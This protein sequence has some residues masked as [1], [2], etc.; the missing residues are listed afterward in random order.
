MCYNCPPPYFDPN[1]N[2]AGDGYPLNGQGCPYLPH[3]DPH[4]MFH[5]GYLNEKVKRYE[6]SLLYE[7]S[8]KFI[9]QRC[10]IYGQKGKVVAAVPNTKLYTTHAC[11]FIVE[12]DS[13]PIISGIIS[14][15]CPITFEGEEE[16]IYQK[17]IKKLQNDSIQGVV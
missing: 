14:E 11:E 3:S 5:K 13:G 4:S 12:L 15:G 8:F 10:T 16:N 9:G 6:K 2:P 1:C 17:H 7:S